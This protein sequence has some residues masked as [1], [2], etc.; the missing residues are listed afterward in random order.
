MSVGQ[1]DQR[2]SRHGWRTKYLLTRIG[3]RSPLSSIHLLDACVNFLAAGRWLR[4]QGYHLKKRVNGSR[5]IFELVAQ[6]VEDRA[7]LYMEFG[8]Y[9]GSMMRV[10]SRLLRHPDA[11]LHGF[12]SF[13]GLPESWRMVCQRGDFNS[14]GHVPAIDDPRV[15]FFKG[16]FEDTLPHYVPPDNECLII[17]IDCDLYSSAKTALKYLK[18]HIKVGTYIYFDEFNNR[19]H[20]L[21]AWDEFIREST[22]QFDLLAADATLTHVLFRRTA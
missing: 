22:M 16:W 4:C 19:E 6:C 9:R 15:R 3:E 13:E 12:D 20:E 18:P 14:D 5:Q 10:W 7:V 8:V 2:S 17:N 1:E 11:K 21:K